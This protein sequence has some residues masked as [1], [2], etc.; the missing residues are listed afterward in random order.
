MAF[1]G[2]LVRIWTVSLTVT[3]ERSARRSWEER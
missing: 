3:L 1:I 2:L